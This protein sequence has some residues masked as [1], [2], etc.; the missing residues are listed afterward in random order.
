MIT[1]EKV[2]LVVTVCNLIE[3]GRSKCEQFYPST[4]SEVKGL[5]EMGISVVPNG[6]EQL[7]PTLTLRKFIVDDEFTGTKQREVRQLHYTGWPDHGV[8]TGEK[9]ME[10]FKLLMDYFLLT[11]LSSA[12]DERIVVHC[13]AGIGRTGTTI[14]LAHMILN[15]WAQKNA[16]IADPQISVFST[17]R[18]LREQR[19]YQVQSVDQYEFLHLFF[20]YYLRSTMKY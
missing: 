16:G 19:F 4:G 2:V 17:I 3:D 5:N 1:Q 18:R 6:E 7:S 13:S 15:T 20:A 9:N 12:Q 11:I 10:S 14:G 8:P